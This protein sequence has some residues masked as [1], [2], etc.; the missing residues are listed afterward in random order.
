VDVVDWAV[1]ILP[2]LVELL[3]GF[4]GV[5]CRCG[6]AVEQCGEADEEMVEVVGVEPG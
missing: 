6:C 4:A 5:I 3:C 1:G 2:M